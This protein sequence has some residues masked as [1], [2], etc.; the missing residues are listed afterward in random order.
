[1]YCTGIGITFRAL[2]PFSSVQLKVTIGTMDTRR[3]ARGEVKS[4]NK[5]ANHGLVIEYEH[6]GSNGYGVWLL[7]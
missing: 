4:I 6:M 3:N 2:P 5:R 1:M 7:M